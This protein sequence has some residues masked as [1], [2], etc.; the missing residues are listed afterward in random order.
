[1]IGALAEDDR[2][3]SVGLCDIRNSRGQVV[4]EHYRVAVGPQAEKPGGDG[5][6]NDEVDREGAVLEGTKLLPRQGLEGNDT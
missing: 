5:N 4:R 1:M 3:E 2:R 6:A